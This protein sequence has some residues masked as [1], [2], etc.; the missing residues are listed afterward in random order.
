MTET[1]LFFSVGIIHPSLKKKKKAKPI[2]VYN[3]IRDSI[4]T[5]SE[6]AYAADVAF[7]NR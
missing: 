7:G 6:T 5:E 2:H 3:W 1:I 4:A